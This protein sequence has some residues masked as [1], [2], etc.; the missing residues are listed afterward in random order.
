VSPIKWFSFHEVLAFNWTV[1]D[2]T[3]TKSSFRVRI[4]RGNQISQAKELIKDRLHLVRD[5]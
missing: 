2:V 1:A 4:E 3:H 5:W